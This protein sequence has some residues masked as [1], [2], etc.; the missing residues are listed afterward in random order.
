MPKVSN[1][2]SFENL[3]FILRRIFA[4]NTGTL[5]STSF[6]FG[7]ALAVEF[8]TIYFGTLTA[9]VLPRRKV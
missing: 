4:A 6:A 7:K 3:N 5:F 1:L 8:E 2:L 9:T